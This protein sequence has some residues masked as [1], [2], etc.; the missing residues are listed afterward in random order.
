MAEKSKGNGGDKEQ[1]CEKVAANHQLH[2]K[3]RFRHQG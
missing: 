2:K 1:H 3:R